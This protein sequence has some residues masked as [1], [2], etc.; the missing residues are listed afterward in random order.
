VSEDAVLS[1]EFTGELYLWEARAGSWTFVD[2][3]V[4]LSEDIRVALPAPPRGFGSVRVEV[5]IGA[6]KWRT[7]LFPDKARGA[8]VL[9]VKRAVLRAQK[10]EAGDQVTVRVAVLS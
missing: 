9:P 4:D 1:A 5:S 7:S 3:P 10:V 2:A 8:Y 6:T